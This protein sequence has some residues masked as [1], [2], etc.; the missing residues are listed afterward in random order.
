MHQPRCVIG[1]NMKPTQN[2]IDYACSVEQFN[3]HTNLLM[4]LVF[5]AAVVVLILDIFV[6]R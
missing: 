5:V 4:K 2:Q 3:P 1:K 6:W